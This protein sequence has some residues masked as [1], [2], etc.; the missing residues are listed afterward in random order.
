MKNRILL[1][2]SIVFLIFSCDQFVNLGDKSDNSADNTE[3]LPDEISEER[4]DTASDANYDD[5]N[6]DSANTGSYENGDNSSAAD[7]QVDTD[8]TNSDAG[9]DETNTTD[10]DSEIPDESQDEEN[11]GYTF[12]E[13]G[14]PFLGGFSNSEC[15]CGEAPQYQPLCCDGKI[16]VFNVCFA[17]CYAV[18]SGNKIC[19]SYEAGLCNGAEAND[20]AE[21][22]VN[23]QDTEIIDDTDE[24]LPDSD[25]VVINNECGCYPGDDTEIFSCGNDSYAITS[26]LAN[27]ICDDPQKIFF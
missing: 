12:P 26:C 20:G 8:N 3:G 13:S 10:T 17:N 5:W 1:I 7:D 21:S 16:S 27:C 4:G 11:G 23:D 2:F 15:N 6:E 25:T 24:E 22:E 19:S 14:D 9:S 18:N